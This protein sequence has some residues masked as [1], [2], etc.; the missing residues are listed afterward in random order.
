MKKAKRSLNKWYKKVEEYEI[1]EISN[2]MST[3]QDNE[4]CILNYFES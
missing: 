4:D 2:F 1:E 3:V